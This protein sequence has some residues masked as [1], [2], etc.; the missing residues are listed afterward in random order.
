MSCERVVAEVVFEALVEGQL[1]ACERRIT[2]WLYASIKAH[3]TFSCLIS[4][5]FNITFVLF[6]EH[7]LYSH[8]SDMNSILRASN[9]HEGDL[10]MRGSTTIL[11]TMVNEPLP[12]VQWAYSEND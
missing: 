12:A 8:L 7:C 10:H 2:R 4:S 1:Q 11:P 6:K 5:R 3:L 9:R